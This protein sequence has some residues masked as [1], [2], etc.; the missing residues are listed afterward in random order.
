MNAQFG[1]VLPL[2]SYA[3]DSGALLDRAAGEVGLAHVTVPA[4]SGPQAQFRLHCDP[5][6][7]YFHTGGGWH[8]PPSAKFYGL[9]GVRPPKAVWFGATDYLARLQEH[10]GRLDLRLVLRVDVRAVPALT[11]HEPQLCQRNAWGQEVPS[12]GACACHPVVR[13]LLRATLEDLRRYQ[14]AAYELIDFFPDK[15]GDR[16]AA[17]PLTWNAPVRQ[18][19][20][21][22]FCASCRQTAER[23]GVDADAAARSVRVQ[24]QHGL[25]APPG[26]QEE[27]PVMREYV[28]ARTSDTSAWLA[29]V[30]ASDRG[31]QYLTHLSHSPIAAEPAGAASDGLALPVWRPTFAESASLVR[32]VTDAAS[33]GV[34]FFDFEALDEAP[35]DAVTWLKQAVRFARR[36]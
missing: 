25:S 19:A 3:A 20:D 31:R 6:K 22:C 12:A 8:F 10:V 7:P 28:A 4:V 13:E 33:R 14:P 5:E 9:T 27:D 29:A 24:I 34:Q 21:R 11:E 26:D 36:G 35:P 15:A 2:W 1:I 23:A 30:T 17:R 16:A 18:L 32:T